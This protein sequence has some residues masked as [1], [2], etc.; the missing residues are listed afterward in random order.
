MPDLGIIVSDAEVAALPGWSQGTSS[1]WTT[2]E[3]F[4]VRMVEAEILNETNLA[5]ALQTFTREEYTVEPPV[6]AGDITTHARSLLILKHSPVKVFTSL[7]IVSQR[8]VTTGA[9]SVVTAMPRNAYSVAMSSGIITMIPGYAGDPTANNLWP[10]YGTIPPGIGSVLATYQGG[11]GA[12]STVSYDL[13]GVVLMVISRTK[14]KFQNQDFE[15]T[16]LS[17]PGGGAVSYLDID[18]TKREQ[19]IIDSYKRGC[20]PS[21]H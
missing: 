4:I 17:M 16:S 1:A 5:V 12:V 3:Q 21:F 11:I 6:T 10:F 20:F 8:D 7:E 18:Y 9:P 13:K 19:R 2:L 15:A 14:K